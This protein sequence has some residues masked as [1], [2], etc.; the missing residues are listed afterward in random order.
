M[1][2]CGMSATIDGDM[3]SA[4]QTSA[5]STKANRPG[6]LRFIWIV[7]PACILAEFRLL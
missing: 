2:Y 1:L 5:R 3:S 4:T 6:I 7:P